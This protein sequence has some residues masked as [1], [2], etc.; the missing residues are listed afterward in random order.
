MEATFPHVSPLQGTRECQS[1]HTLTYAAYYYCPFCGKILKPKPLPTSNF[2]QIGIYSFCIFF[3][4]LG[5]WPAWKYLH[6]KSGKARFIA[7]MAI[8]LTVVSTI[9][10]T[11][12]TLLF[13]QSAQ[14]FLKGQ[15]LQ[16]SVQNP[17]L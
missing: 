17:G 16:L 6:E 14:T 4:P 8:I 3:P 9:V 13:M 2:R 12:Y 1:C 5:L 15:G 10:T 11:Y 7:V